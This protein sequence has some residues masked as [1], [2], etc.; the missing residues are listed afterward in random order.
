MFLSSK[1]ESRMS[2]GRQ[3]LLKRSPLLLLPVAL[4]AVVATLSPNLKVAVAQP[5]TCV[6][7]VTGRSNVCTANDV[8]I[9]SVNNVVSLACIPGELVSLELRAEFVANA[10]ERYDIGLFVAEDGGDAYTGSCYKDYL[11]PPLARNG[12]CSTSGAICQKDADC[13]LG[14][15]CTGGYVPGDPFPLPDGGPFWDGEPGD[16]SDLC[17]DLE[18]GV[19]TFYDLAPGTGIVVPCIDTNGDGRLDIGTVSSWDNTANNTCTGSDDAVPNTKSKCRGERVEVGNVYVSKFVEVV[20]A[21]VPPTD[22]GLFDL[23]IDATT[24]FTDASHAD[25]TGP[26]EVFTPTA[27]VGE[28][29][30]TGT[31]L[32]DYSSSILCYDQVGR[33]SENPQIHCTNDAVCRLADPPAGVCDFP[34]PIVASCDPCTDLTLDIPALQTNILCTITNTLQTGS[35]TIVKDT[36]PPGA[37]QEFDFASSTTPANFSLSDGENQP[38]PDLTPG[39][40]T[41]TETVPL[42]WDLDRV[43]CVGQEQSIVTP[44]TDGVDVELAPRENVVCTFYNLEQFG[45]ITIVKDTDPPDS[46][47]VFDFA[48]TTPP[49]AFSLSDGESQPFPDLLPGLYTF[50]ETVPLAWDLDRVECVGQEQSVVTPITG[51]VDVE[52]APME[53]VVCTFY[54]REQPGT[55]IVEKQTVP[56]GSPQLFDFT[57]DYGQPFQ[58]SDGQTNDSGPLPK[59]TYAVT[60]TVPPGWFLTGATCADGSEPAAIDLQAGETVTCTFTN[61]EHAI[62]VDKAC[63]EDVFWCDD[64]DYQ[65]TVTNTGGVTLTDVLVEDPIIGLEETVDLAPGEFRTFTGTYNPCPP[66][67]IIVEKLTDPAGSTQP[68]DF[69]SS[70]GPFTLRDGETD[71]SGPLPPGTYSVSESVP[72]GWHLTSAT[73]DDGS[74]PADIDLQPA[75]I[76]TCTF[77]NA[78]VYMVYLPVVMRG[79]N[80]SLVRI[81][82]SGRASAP[83]SAP[84]SARAS[85]FGAPETITNTVT[86]TSLYLTSEV[87]ATDSCST[88]VYRPVVTKDANTSFLRTYKWTIDKSVDE[89]GPTLLYVGDFVEPEYAVV[90]DLDDPPFVDTEML[91]SGTITVANPAPMDAELLSVT[92]LVSPGHVPTVDCPTLT[93]PAGGSLICTYGPLE[94]PST[95][96]RTNTATATLIN[97]NGGAT[98][99]SDTVNVDF[100]QPTTVIDAEVQVSDS[101]FGPFGTVRYDEVPRSFPESTRIVAEGDV[102]ELFEV[103]NEAVFVTNDTGA[104]GSDLAVVQVFELCTVTLGYEDLPIEQGNDWDYNDLIYDVSPI[105]DASPDH[106]MLG[107]SLTVNQE[108]G[109]GPPANLTAYHHEAH[110]L[111]DPNEFVCSGTYTMTT[112]V[113]SSTTTDTGTFNPGDDFTIIQDTDDPPDLVELEIDFDVPPVTGCPFELADFNFVDYHH[114]EWLFFDPWLYVYNTGEEI[115]RGT[116]TVVEPRILTV[117]T[118]WVWPVPDGKLVCT[119][120]PKVTGCVPG[121]PDFPNFWWIN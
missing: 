41:F 85:A 111:L 98:K 118:D 82:L 12:S 34:Y 78:R 66:G 23:Q 90:V 20:K 3:N 36:D 83:A 35:S 32:A 95:S 44:T 120:Y 89:P 9:A 57:T 27:T 103:D 45:S 88:D 15:T 51:G 62:T 53:N 100:G 101:M 59:G 8:R 11:P 87:T 68:F 96:G 70:W 108:P 42:G 63:T 38:F 97:N 72:E 40:Y 73:C 24:W 106:D 105:F 26:Q 119:P 17:G 46:L 50:T 7:D 110:L 58:L 109:A 6:D 14:E 71:F 65:V 69:T 5:G 49:L 81:P 102:C 55:I 16:A 31:S 115:H 28:L 18:Q 37:A 30:G 86:A 60:E 67:E 121:P 52:L 54:N 22:V 25:T 113:D 76:V 4:L 107:L 47:Q 64:I 2:Q 80:P 56:P 104:T 75:E 91:V 10:N 93:V 92:D 79:A 117:P 48:S 29:A 61:N 74:D 116:E 99:F 77:T 39:L 84:A 13:P 112:T 21:L 1:E 114:A 94:L 33:C 19:N 43:E